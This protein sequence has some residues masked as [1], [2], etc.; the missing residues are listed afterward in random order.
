MK[1][2]L[3]LTIVLIAAAS[4]LSALD[5]VVGPKIG[6][7]DYNF[8]GDYVP[9]DNMI[10]LS[11]EVGAFVNLQLTSMIGLQIEAMYT[12]QTVRCDLGS[13][14]WGQYIMNALSLPVY[15][16]FDFDLAGFGIYALAG[17]QFDLLFGD[18]KGKDS[19]GSTYNNG[20]VSDV[21]DNI[22]FINLAAG[23]GVSLP[24]GPGVLD[25]G[26]GIKYG[27]TQYQDGNDWKAWDIDIQAAYGF[28][29]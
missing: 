6:I 11:P 18:A 12:Y 22:F 8:H 2:I 23:A 21:Y 20:S 3:I 4:S 28:S 25:V 15:A 24:F 7:A 1:R 26:A 27:L 13:G 9:Y 29:I 16:R 10:S 19:D 14:D 5:F 17:A